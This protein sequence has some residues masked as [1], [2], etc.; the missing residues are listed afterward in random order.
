MVLCGNIWGNTSGKFDNPR[1]VLN[2]VFFFK[3]LYDTKQR[4]VGGTCVL[5]FWLIEKFWLAPVYHCHV[6]SILSKDNNRRTHHP[7]FAFSFWNGN[8]LLTAYWLL[9]TCLLL[10][11]NCLQQL[12]TKTLST[13]SALLWNSRGVLGN[14]WS[15]YLQL[16]SSTS[17]PWVCENLIN[18]PCSFEYFCYAYL[19]NLHAI[20]YIFQSFFQRQIN[21]HY[22][23]NC[24]LNTK[25][26]QGFSS[27]VRD[28][29]ERQKSKWK[30]VFDWIFG[31]EDIIYIRSD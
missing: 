11:H 21:N 27:Q 22:P 4:Q 14:A 1:G 10:F 15:M 6:F 3:C 8:W 2:V 20:A 19:A 9:T 7:Q 13:C 29:N 12:L 31:G 18:L 16:K 17:R 30:A 23:S 28:K 5:P 26:S 24:S 25:G